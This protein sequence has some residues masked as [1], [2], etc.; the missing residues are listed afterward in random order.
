MPYSDFTVMVNTHLTDKDGMDEE[1]IIEEM[2]KAVKGIQG[3]GV[4]RT[5]FPKTKPGKYSA[6]LEGWAPEK[7][8]S[9]GAYHIHFNLSLEHPGIQLS[10]AEGNTTGRFKNYFDE[11][12]PWE[13]KCHCWVKLLDSSRIKN[14]NQKKAARTVRTVEVRNKKSNRDGGAPADGDGEYDK[15]VNQR[16]AKE[17]ESGVSR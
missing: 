13:K 17:D 1:Y 14:Y 16:E 15:S 2:V 9:K 7:G 8:K 12:F 10:D 6:R 4:L 5:L 11:A 3:P